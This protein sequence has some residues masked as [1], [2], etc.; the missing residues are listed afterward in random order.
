MLFP[1]LYPMGLPETY[2]FYINILELLSIMFIRTRSSLKFY[3]KFILLANVWFLAYCNSYLYAMM[4]EAV[5]FLFCLSLFLFLGFLKY[6]EY[7][8]QNYWSP[9]GIFTPSLHNPRQGYIRVPNTNF[10]L[11]GEIWS[12]F[13][14]L[15]FRQ[16]FTPQEQHEYD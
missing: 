6:Y 1:A 16:R 3:P 4:Y 5:S 10:G 11:A 13:L 14:P 15:R 2:F 7:E 8:S 9:F 12:Q